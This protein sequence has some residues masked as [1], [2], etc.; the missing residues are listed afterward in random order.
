MM[1]RRQSYM[2][3]LLLAVTV[4]AVL[5]SMTGCTTATTVGGSAGGHGL[6]SSLWAETPVKDGTAEIASYTVWLGLFDVG[7]SDYISAVKKAVTDGKLVT[8][9][10][11]WFYI[12][13]K[14][15]AYV[16]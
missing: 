5:F 13:S 16:Q 2:K 12:F 4:C 1:K 15:T 7:H 6:I 11:K 10:T 9:S 3:K 14:T 8:S